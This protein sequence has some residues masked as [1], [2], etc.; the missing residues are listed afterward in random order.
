MVF[1]VW[2]DGT[3]AGT[4]R[5]PGRDVKRDLAMHLY[6][7]YLSHSVCM[8]RILPGRFSSH[9]AKRDN[10]YHIST[11]SSFAGTILCWLYK[12]SRV[13]SSRE[14]TFLCNTRD[15]KRPLPANVPNRQTSPP[16]KRPLPANVP[17]RQTSRN[18][19]SL[20]FINFHLV[21]GPID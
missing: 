11:T 16:G 13:K 7:S 20:T 9:P 12:L 14:E 21:N 4:G 2:N 5:L 3:F 19:P 10:F 1:R 15:W 8:E 18:T 6:I 17:N